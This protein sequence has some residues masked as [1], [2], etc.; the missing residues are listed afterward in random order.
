MIGLFFISSEW[1]ER[2]KYVSA[3]ILPKIAKK[4]RKI[5]I[6]ISIWTLLVINILFL[7]LL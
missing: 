6:P 5:G 4:L 3:K 7:S 1:L 2:H